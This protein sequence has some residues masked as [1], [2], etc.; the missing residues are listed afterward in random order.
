MDFAVEY[1]V[2]EDAFFL[3]ELRVLRGFCLEVPW[4]CLERFFA[5]LLMRHVDLRFFFNLDIN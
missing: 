1:V 2:E 4:L 3:V 5:I